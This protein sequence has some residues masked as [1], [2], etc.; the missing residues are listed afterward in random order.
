MSSIRCYNYDAFSLAEKFGWVN[1][2][3]GLNA[4]ADAA[5]ALRGMSD[6]LG[7]INDGNIQAAKK[8]GFDW[9]GPAAGAAQ[10]SLTATVNEASRTEQV[11]A[12]GADRIMDYGHSFESMRGRIAFDDPAKYSLVQRAGDE[13]SHEWDTIS[14]LWGGGGDHITVAERNVGYNLAANDVLQQHEM[15]SRQADDAFQTVGQQPPPAASGTGQGGG[16]SG[17]G[18]GGG[19]PGASGPGGSGPDGAGGSGGDRYVSPQQLAPAPSGGG[20]GAPPTPHQP[21]T[22]HTTPPAGNPPGGTVPAPSAPGR[23]GPGNA[24][25]A[26]NANPSAPRSRVPGAPGRSSGDGS[27]TSDGPGRDT[28]RAPRPP[29]GVPDHDDV[30]N[31]ANYPSSN[32]P[33]RIGA[34][35]GSPSNPGTDFGQD[36]KRSQLVPSAPSG[37]D[38]LGGYGGPGGYGSPG[39]YR[40]GGPNGPRIG[41]PNG[42]PGQ[43][44]GDLGS[45]TGGR[46][47]STW[48]GSGTGGRWGTGAFGRAPGGELG[49]A[50]ESRTLPRAGSGA[51]GEGAGGGRGAPFGEAPGRG[52]ASS[53]TAMGGAPMGGGAGG[54]RGDQEHRNRY[55]L[56]SSEAFEVEPE[57]TDAV[58]GPL[59]DEDY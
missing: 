28:A 39:G 11:G 42:L 53:S 17:T 40:P 58:L 3:P 19:A 37:P 57:C 5:Q 22:P 21:A 31:S 24:T 23:G 51:L 8:L 59:D 36:L 27:G 54:G 47:A 44:I 34:A 50:P 2:K 52:G 6:R 12:N 55:Q 25:T 9:S 48:S 49:G 56:A 30:T 15:S 43:G 1:G 13:L 45:E 4:V 16:G 32:D 38:G 7:S 46:G 18:G 10:K 33:F 35:P 41:P 29:S 26:E 20:T 14:N